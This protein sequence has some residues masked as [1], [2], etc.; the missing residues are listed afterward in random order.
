MLC[1]V[2]S[3]FVAGCRDAGAMF[4][5]TLNDFT[6]IECEGEHWRGLSTLSLARPADAIAWQVRRGGAAT[7]FV[8]PLG[9][10]LQQSYGSRRM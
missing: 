8:A 2:G 4:P 6:R 10:P 7:N 3:L 9:V 1:L 5:S